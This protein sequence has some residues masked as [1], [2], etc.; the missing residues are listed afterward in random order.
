MS[1]TDMRSSLPTRSFAT[2]VVDRKWPMPGEGMNTSSS[3]MTS[4]LSFEFLI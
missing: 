1:V 3:S 2:A 4:T